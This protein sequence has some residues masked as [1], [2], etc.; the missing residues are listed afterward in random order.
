MH[1]APIGFV[2]RVDFLAYYN[3]VNTQADTYQLRGAT[4][5]VIPT[6]APDVVVLFNQNV[7]GAEL[8]MNTDAQDLRSRATSSPTA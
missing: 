5:G 8:Q 4:N 3:S 2:D 1:D 7:T 6:N